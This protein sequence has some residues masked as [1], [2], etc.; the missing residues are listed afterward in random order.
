MAPPQRFTESVFLRL[1]DGTR[2][3]IEALREDGEPLADT[4]RRVVAAGL[5]ALEA[6]RSKIIAH[7]PAR[8][9]A[10]QRKR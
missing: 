9:A 3:R 4:Q 7:K 10:K 1:A 8:Q 5:A 6:R 2:R